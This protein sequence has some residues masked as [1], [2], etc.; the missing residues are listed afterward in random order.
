MIKQI[1]CCDICKN[2]VDESLLNKYKSTVGSLEIKKS[3]T[4]S[5]NHILLD[6]CENCH[7]KIYNFIESLSEKNI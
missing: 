6:I 3:Y 5:D 4:F 2:E 1:Y 7:T